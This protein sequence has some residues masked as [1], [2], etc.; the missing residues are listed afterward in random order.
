[1]I[2]TDQLNRRIQFNKTPKRIVSLVPSLT[3]LLVDLGLEDS[4]V[5]VTKF[6][7]H[8]KHLRLSK[9]MV[10]GTKQINIQKIIGLQPDIVLC[11]KEE[12]TKEIVEA[13]EFISSIH[14]SD[15][16]NLHDCYELIHMYGQLFKVEDSASALINV[17]KNE[18]NQFQNS[19]KQQ[20][21][22]KVVYFIWKKPWMI[23]GSGTFIH[24]MI[25]EAGFENVFESKE[26]YPKI[27]LSHPKLK[28]AD[29]LL[30]S[31]EP[32]PFKQDDVLA[33]KSE[34]PKASIEI[35]DGELFSWYGSRLLKSFKYFESFHDRK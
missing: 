5:G 26:R 9:I 24:H 27:V 14:I 6:C 28:D 12:N 3:E 34:F 22:Q 13:L 8:P 32:Y 7:V 23:A 2:F 33:L 20:S 30:L 35:V 25:K 21:K 1:M 31:S 17:I 19:I 11:N 29:R 4:I 10:G 15:I 16:K 18:R